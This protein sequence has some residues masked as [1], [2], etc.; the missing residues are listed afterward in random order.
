MCRRYGWSCQKL[1]L[2]WSCCTVFILRQANLFVRDVLIYFFLKVIFRANELVKRVQRVAGLSDPQERHNFLGYQSS[3]G[4][5]ANKYAPYTLQNETSLPFLFQL[6][7]GLVNQ[8]EVEIVSVKQGNVV[9]PGSSVPVYTDETPD[10][11][12]L[13]FRPPQSSDRLNEKKSLGMAHHLISIQLDGTCGPSRPI[14]VDIVGLTYFEVNFSKAL[15]K[16]SVEANDDTLNSMKKTTEN[17]KMDPNSG[18]VVPVV[19]DV[20]T[21]HYRKLI[22]VY[23][24]VSLK[25]LIFCYYDFVNMFFYCL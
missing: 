11:Q 21:L 13:R 12:F 22:R 17:R 24:T 2:I 15:E 25:F 1:D 20:S 6:H 14:S 16:D 9:Y 7:R 19:F 3:D 8:D 23:S 10:E 5:F 4:L 18:F